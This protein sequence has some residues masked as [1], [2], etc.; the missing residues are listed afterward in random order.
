MNKPETDSEIDDSTNYLDVIYNEKRRPASNYPVQL[1]E[2]LTQVF[3]DGEKL[4]VL[5]LGCG[6]GDMLRALAQCGHEVVGTDLS[7]RVVELC[8]PFEAHVCDLTNTAVP[9][10]DNSMDV[11]FSKSVIEHLHEP[12]PMLNEAMRVLKPGGRLILMTPSW[13]HHAF[14]PFYLDYTHVT[15]YTAP[16]LRDVLAMSGFSDIFVQHFRQL[17]FVWKMPILTPIAWLFSS[18]PLPYTPLDEMSWKW[19]FG[20]NNLLR[21]SKEM[22]LL[23]VSRKLPTNN[24]D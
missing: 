1:A 8:A 19:S 15:P 5:D 3:L 22:M 6:R 20:I 23:S 18:L 11:V 17:P 24:T 7:E 2:H 4:R 9:F 12:M 16:S 14:G 10:P 13:R 21:F